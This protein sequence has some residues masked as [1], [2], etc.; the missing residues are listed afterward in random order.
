M[1]IAGTEVEPRALQPVLRQ[2]AKLHMQFGVLMVA[3]W[4]AAVAVSAW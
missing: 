3:G 2:T 1:R 4:I